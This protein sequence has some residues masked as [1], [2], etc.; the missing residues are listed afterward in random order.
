MENWFRRCLERGG[1]FVGY[2]SE[3]IALIE[4]LRKCAETHKEYLANNEAATRACL[5]D[6]VLRILG[7]DVSDPEQVRVE[8]KVEGKSADYAL[9]RDAKPHILI[10]AKS[11]GAKIKDDFW[12]L[13]VYAARTGAALGVMTNGDE[14]VFLDPTDT[15]RPK[16]ASVKLLSQEIRSLTL[17][18]VTHLDAADDATDS[19]TL[20]LGCSSQEAI[21]GDKAENIGKSELERTTPVVSLT[22]LAAVLRDAGGKSKDL[23]LRKL[24]WPD[25]REVPIRNTTE[26]LREVAKSVVGSLLLP[27]PDVAGKKRFILAEQPV[28]K[29]GR[30]FKHISSVGG[31]YLE[32]NYSAHNCIRNAIHLLRE[33]R[34][35]PESL[36]V[37]L[38]RKP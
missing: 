21:H 22:V 34:L 10:E 1:F 11:L 26:L 28:H 3:F 27:L 35:D 23:P 17:D 9:L 38:Q 13:A 6:P 4:R 16:R 19:R 14:W 7:W 31:R 29:D 36:K 18:L 25:G 12:Q 2:L 5:V 15:S 20:P 37:E 30:P 33:A 32:T 24:I 8:Y